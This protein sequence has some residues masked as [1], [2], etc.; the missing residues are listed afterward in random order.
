MQVSDEVVVLA[1]P[2]TPL[3]HSTE[4]SDTTMS[5]QL[6]ATSSEL[7][8]ELKRHGI[9]SCAPP[10]SSVASF[11]L[12]SRPAGGQ[13]P[14]SRDCWHD[15]GT[16]ASVDYRETAIDDYVARLHAE[17]YDTAEQFRE[18]TLTELKEEL[19]FKPG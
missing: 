16:V 14:L 12:P 5:R 13:C 18:L 9:V 15:I 17:G 8:E 3:D 1:T 7:K 11:A 6:S 10:F 4:A 19:S 2:A